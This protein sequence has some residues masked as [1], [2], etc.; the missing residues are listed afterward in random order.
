MNRLKN[1]AYG[2]IVI[3]LVSGFYGCATAP[4]KVT[5][6]DEFPLMYEEAPTSIL[7][8]PPMN[9]ST[10]AEAKGYYATTIQ[11]ILSYRGYYIFPYEI[12]ADIFKMEGI[13]DAEI[14]RDVPLVKFREFFGADAVLF[15]T[16]KK[17]D[18]SYVVLA[19]KLTVAIE[20]M[21]KST[22]SDQVLWKYNGTVVVN[23]SGSSGGASLV[24][25]IASIVITAAQSAMADYVPHAR[26]AN[27][28]AFSSM[29][30][31]KY[32]PQHLTDQSM[33]II[34][35]TTEHRE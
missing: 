31:G 34:D 29:P 19:S 30:F 33:E 27:Y 15:T 8:M 2:I 22:K 17:W 32:H 10:A 21:L 14:I 9:E 26:T 3:F 28:R 6:G 16:I 12:T 1:K 13:Y 18:L 20:C 35:Q 5:K 4:S 25:L 24:D 11:E 23:L 7:I